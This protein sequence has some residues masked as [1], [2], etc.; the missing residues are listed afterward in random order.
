MRR[1]VFI[2]AGVVGLLAISAAA[3]AVA[4]S[5]ANVKIGEANEK[6]FFGP[7][8]AYV[9]VGGTVVWTNGTD[10]PHTVTSDSGAE[11]DSGTVAAAATFSHTFATAGTFAYHCTVHP[12]MV[13]KVVVLAA[14]VALPQTDTAAAARTPG[15]GSGI[16]AAPALLALVVGLAGAA[17]AVRR[18]RASG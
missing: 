16:P 9:N 11:L 10:A 14:G 18:V 7:A 3:G 17:L 8:T 15:D 13:A 6:Y 1:R 5:G 12:Y 2:V 4:A